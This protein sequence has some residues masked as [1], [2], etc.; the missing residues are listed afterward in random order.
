MNDSNLASL[1]GNS[2]VRQG[3]CVTSHVV[4]NEEDEIR[5]RLDLDYS[6]S[7]DKGQQ[8]SNLQAYIHNSGR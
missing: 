7:Q 1:Y 3:Y 5:I 8:F 4:R 2:Y 6:Q